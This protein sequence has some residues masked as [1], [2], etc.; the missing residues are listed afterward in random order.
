MTLI[1]GW[2]IKVILKEIFWN[3]KG[4]T[5][6]EY[7]MGSVLSIYDWW[8]D[9]FT[10][11]NCILY[12]LKVVS[13]QAVWF[14]KAQWCH[15]VLEILVKTGSDY[16]LLPDGTK[17][18]PEPSVDMPSVRSSDIHYWFLFTGK[19]CL[20]KTFNSSPPGQNGRHFVDR[21]KCIFM[22]ENLFISIQISPMFVQ[23]QAIT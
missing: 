11:S 2:P 3:V 6:T 14:I 16:G 12:H 1:P 18:L 19:Q 10:P 20:V 22:D 9:V 7:D 23:Q 5:G 17:P 15:V 21:F 13:W 4:I 8:W